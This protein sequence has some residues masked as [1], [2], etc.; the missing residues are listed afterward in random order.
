MYQHS[1]RYCRVALLQSSCII[2]FHHI[3]PMAIRLLIDNCIAV[4][5]PSSPFTLH[6]GS[7]T[8]DV[9]FALGVTDVDTFSVSVA[10]IELGKSGVLV[11]R[12]GFGPSSQGCFPG[13]GVG[14]KR[15]LHLLMSECGHIC[16]ESPTTH[17][18]CWGWTSTEG[19]HVAPVREVLFIHA[20]LVI[21]Y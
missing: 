12:G 16:F 14:W 4:T 19:G 3:L 21:E 2:I 6:T 17:S 13:R 9:T 11:L 18:P 7:V 10:G 1:A 15:S 8:G 5:K 20:S